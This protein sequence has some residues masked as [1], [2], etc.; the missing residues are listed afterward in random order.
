MAGPTPDDADPDEVERLPLDLQYLAES[1]TV[2]EDPDLRRMLLEAL[3]QL[4][5]TRAGRRAVRDAGSYA[6]LKE[7]HAKEQDR[8]VKLACENLVSGRVQQSTFHFG[9]FVV[10]CKK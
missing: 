5:A 2:E 9:N 10:R 1:K 7:L 8:Q 4:C 6:I 3:T